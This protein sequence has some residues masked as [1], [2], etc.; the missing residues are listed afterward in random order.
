MGNFNCRESEN[1]LPMSVF[2]FS[3][4]LM[5]TLAEKDFPAS[6][7]GLRTSDDRGPYLAVAIETFSCITCA[8]ESSVE[9]HV[10]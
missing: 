8:A 10:T 7:F 6:D 2:F 5:T 4:F 9:I 3:D 1:H